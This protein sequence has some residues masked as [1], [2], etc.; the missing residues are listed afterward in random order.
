MGDAHDAAVI[1][2]RRCAQMGLDLSAAHM[3]FE[4]LY[5]AS[6][7]SRSNGNKSEA[8]RQSGVDRV[9]IHRITK[10]RKMGGN[11]G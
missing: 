8:A 1:I 4:A 2:G 10:R 6:A 7:L 3:V 5:V 9:T 11:D